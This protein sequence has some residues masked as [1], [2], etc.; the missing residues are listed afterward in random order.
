MTRFSVIIPVYNVES[1]LRECLDSV[2]CQTFQDWEAICVN[3][4][5]SD[6]SLAI[7]DEYAAK[8]SR[9]KVVSQANG[10]LSA[11]RNTGIDNASGEYIVFLDSDDWIEYNTLEILD[12]HLRTPNSDLQ[13]LDMLCFSGRR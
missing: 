9:F 4:G 8:D 11:A 13:P 6:N 12:T 7:L 3:D 2:L 10:G 5:S 1:Y